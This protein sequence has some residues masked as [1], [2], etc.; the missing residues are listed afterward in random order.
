MEEE[1]KVKAGFK[2]IV[3]FHPP[4][5]NACC[6]FLLYMPKL[7]GMRLN[8]LV[9]SSCLVQVFIKFFFIIHV[10]FAPVEC[11]VL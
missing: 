1:V 9:I 5:A 2:G 11:S 8:F 7:N 6:G 4:A 3:L 10:Y